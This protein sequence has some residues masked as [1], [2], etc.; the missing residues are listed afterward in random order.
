MGK[1]SRRPKQKN[2]RRQIGVVSSATVLSRK[3]ADDEPSS[4]PPGAACWIC[5][6]RHLDE[7]GKPIVRDCSCRG[8]DAGFVHLSCLAYYAEAKTKELYESGADLNGPTQGP[9]KRG[10]S[11]KG[12]RPDIMTSTSTSG[13]DAD[14]IDP[15]ETC[16][17]C[18]QKYQRRFALEMAEKFVVCIEENYPD[19]KLAKIDG[20]NYVIHAILDMNFVESLALREEGKRVANQIIS[21]IEEI[22]DTTEGMDVLMD[23]QKASAMTAL[24]KF[25][26][27]KDKDGYKLALQCQEKIRDY[28]MSEGDEMSAKQ[29]EAGMKMIK[30]NR[31]GKIDITSSEEALRS[32]RTFYKEMIR[33]HGKE[34]LQSVQAGVNMAKWLYQTRRGVELERL[35]K[36]LDIVSCRV[37]GPEHPLS[38]EVKFHFERS[39]ERIVGVHTD[40]GVM[41]YN[42]FGFNKNKSTYNV[43]KW[44]P[45]HKIYE[46]GMD[47][48]EMASGTPVICHGLKN[49]L[50]LNEKIGDVIRYDPKSC[51]YEVRFED[52]S[53]T[54]A[55]VKKTNLQILFDLP[56][57]Q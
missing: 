49:A 27:A 18:R 10:H 48:F 45:V 20:L 5:L 47:A 43:E 2:K 36:D 28:Y 21:E 16:P 8:D 56:E 3:T 30:A 38:E 19:M 23:A 14:L 11:K 51:R 17:T 13:A 32:T 26:S 7:G 54:S 22:D 24:A 55:S 33:E 4:P 50:H 37:L 46:L 39:R 42:A 12:T 52:K 44:V 29:V 41:Q 31:D 53:L 1:K 25:S 57:T 34:A 40:D 15:W 35:L 9:C 6:D